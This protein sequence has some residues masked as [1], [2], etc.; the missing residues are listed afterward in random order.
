MR[1]S[2]PSRAETWAPLDAAITLV[3]FYLVWRISVPLVHWLLLD[4]TWNGSSR[5]DCKGA[6]ACWVFVRM[7]FG[8]FIIQLLTPTSNGLS[9]SINHHD[10]ASSWASRLRTIQFNIVGIP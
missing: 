5:D 1:F 6:G 8:Q 2:R 7:R 4:A 10:K 3:C 9:I